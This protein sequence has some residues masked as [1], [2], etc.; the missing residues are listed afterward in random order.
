MELAKSSAPY[1]VF[2]MMLA[3]ASVMFAAPVF[4]GADTDFDG[5]NTQI[6]N[7]L[8]GS[9]GTLLALIGVIFGIGSALSGRWGGLITGIGVAAAA[10]YLPAI[11]ETLTTGVV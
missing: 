4:A 11:I 5:L 7:W 2:F 6:T 9:L 3:L 8:E 1:V 10:V